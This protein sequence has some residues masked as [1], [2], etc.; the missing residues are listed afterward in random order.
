MLIA[1]SCTDRGFTKFQQSIYFYNQSGHDL[2]IF[3]FKNQTADT[4]HIYNYEN[5]WYGTF[6]LESVAP[7]YLS[8]S[9]FI[10]FDDNKLVKYLPSD[11]LAKNIL[12]ITTY[13]CHPGDTTDCYFLID[14]DEYLK[15]K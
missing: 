2:D 8:D 3:S 15:A 12:C 1:F 11:C 5:Y 6:S 9:V 7:F 10:E 14:T 13:Y 4:I